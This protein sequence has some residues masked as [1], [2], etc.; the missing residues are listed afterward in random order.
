[1]QIIVRDCIIANMATVMAMMI[2]DEHIPKGSCNGVA[3]TVCTYIEF[4][5]LVY[6]CQDIIIEIETT[7]VLIM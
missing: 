6:M 3:Q 7:C 4:Q 2:D 1:V 5:L